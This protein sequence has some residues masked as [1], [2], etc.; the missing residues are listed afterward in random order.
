MSLR[1]NGSYLSNGSVTGLNGPVTTIE[2][3]VVAG[4]GAGGISGGGGGAGGVLTATG[5]S[6]T[7]G[8]SI[9]ITVGA[10]GAG[11]GYTNRSSITSGN[12]SQFGIII[13]VGGGRGGSEVITNDGIYGNGASGGSGGGAGYGG[14]NTATGGV[15]GL[16]T[17]GQGN[18]GGNNTGQNNT[19]YGGGGGAGSA[20][21]IGIASAYVSG[22]GG[23]GIVSSI[24]GSRVLYGGGGGAG[25]YQYLGSVGIGGGGGGGNG[26]R[27]YPNIPTT[28][29]TPTN[30]LYNTG[31]GG[32]GINAVYGDSRDPSSANGGSGIVVIRHP[33]YL[34]PATS[35]TGSP[36]TYIAGKWRVYVFTTSGTITF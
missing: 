13:A 25:Q 22:N 4:G 30:G 3:L 24:T 32:G 21:T 18:S 6:V 7:S 12:Y 29:I 8:S 14:T 26:G 11:Q 9:T 16:G 15:G 28:N 19:N 34:V 1:Y 36:Q 35:V 2:Y 27:F 20:G 5:Y 10:G 33:S 17:S 23:T 31:G